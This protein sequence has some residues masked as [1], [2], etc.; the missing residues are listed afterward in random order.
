[1]IQSL[2]LLNKSLFL[3]GNDP[4]YKFFINMILNEKLN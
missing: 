2:L 3:I 4:Q 1:M